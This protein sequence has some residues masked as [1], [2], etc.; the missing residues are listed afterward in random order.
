MTN[1]FPKLMTYTKPQTQ[2]SQKTSN[3]INAQKT[4]PKHI[5][6]KSHK[7]KGKKLLKEINGKN[8]LPIEK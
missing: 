1:N 2:E 3:R 6:S 4:I 7:I 5:I 8:T